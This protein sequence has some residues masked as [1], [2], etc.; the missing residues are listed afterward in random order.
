LGWGRQWIV[1]DD[2]WKHEA[3]DLGEVCHETTVRLL[4]A[5]GVGDVAVPLSVGRPIRKVR[6]SISWQRP[7][8]RGKGYGQGM[9]ATS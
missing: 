8:S 2:I 1:I 4:G 6:I 9:S 3:V 5:D 7:A